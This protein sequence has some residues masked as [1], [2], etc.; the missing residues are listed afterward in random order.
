MWRV[1]GNVLVVTL[2]WAQYGFGM[3]SWTNLEPAFKIYYGWTE[4][5]TIFWGDVNTS[6]TVLGGMTGSLFMA[7]K[8]HLLS[9]FNWLILTNLCL[10]LAVLSCLMGN[11]VLLVIGRYVWGTS[12]GIFSVVCAKYVNEFCPIEVKGSFGAFNQFMNVAGGT[13]PSGLAL[14][15]SREITWEMRDSFEVQWYWRVIWS[16][17]ILISVVQVSLLMLFYKHETPVYLKE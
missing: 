5:E 2:G 15:F 3:T 4:D 8:M 1:L 9:K 10:V 17:P 7:N 14:Y 12:Y 13:L 6:L 11:I 16:V